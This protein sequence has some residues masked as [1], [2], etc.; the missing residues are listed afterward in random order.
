MCRKYFLCYMCILFLNGCVSNKKIIACENKIF[1]NYSSIN[2]QQYLS[3]GEKVFKAPYDIVFSSI[4]TGISNMG[5]AIKNMEKESGYILAEGM[6]TRPMKIQK[7]TAEILV[8]EL[9]KCGRTW[10]ARLGNAIYSYSFNLKK[11]NNHI[12]V[13]LRISVVVNQNQ[14]TTLYSSF[15]PKLLET[16]YQHAWRNIEQQLFLDTHLD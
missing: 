11:Y 6:D 10:E 15:H 13:K 3:L 12:K 14:G 16:H 8:N 1:K 4:V 7:Q 2:R 5:I 9:S